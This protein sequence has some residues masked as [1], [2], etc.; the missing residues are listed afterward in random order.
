MN[1][2]P[3]KLSEKSIF[4]AFQQIILPVSKKAFGANIIFSKSFKILRI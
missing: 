2:S 1:K 4:N 3:I